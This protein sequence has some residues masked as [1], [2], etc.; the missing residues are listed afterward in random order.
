MR[1]IV[2]LLMSVLLVLT[3][4]SLASCSDSNVKNEND[5]VESTGIET[6]DESES[7]SESESE[8]TEDEKIDINVIALKGPTGMGMVELMDKNDKGETANKYDITIAGAPDEVSS[9]VI[10]G[11]VDIAAVPVNLASVLYNKTGGEIKIA[12]INTLG[13]L[14]LL[15][16]GN[17]VNSVADLVG[18]T[19]YATG[20]AS[21]PEYILRHVLKS[22]GIDPDNDVTI[23]Y[24]SEHA[25]LATLMAAGDVEIAMLP[26]PNVTSVMLNNSNVRIALDMTEEWNNVTNDGSTLVQ[27]VIIVSR[28]FAENNKEALD[29]FLSEYKSSVEYVNQNTEAAAELIEGYGIIPKKALAMKALPNCNICYI[30]GDEMIESLDGMFGVLFEANPSSI[31]GKIPDDNCYYKK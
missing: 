23:E 25:E 18:K 2:L 12:A 20:Q 21:T 11:H 5:T 10:G 17:T 15:E 1:K 22:N 27:G 8:K 4:M 13:V 24:L 31:G 19:I 7:E 14:Y 3:V 6:S 26:E 16:N 30:D 9:A 29:A 28:D